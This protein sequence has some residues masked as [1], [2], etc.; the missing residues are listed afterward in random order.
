MP[1]MCQRCEELIR[2]YWSIHEELKKLARG[3]TDVLQSREM[4][5]YNGLRQQW[6]E[7]SGESYEVHHLFLAHV[8]SHRI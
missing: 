1:L 4:G 7:F 3:V 2:E 5:L 6:L 8:K